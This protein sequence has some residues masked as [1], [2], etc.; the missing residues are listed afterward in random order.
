MNY[1]CMAV[2]HN[3]SMQPFSVSRNEMASGW[4]LNSVYNAFTKVKWLASLMQTK[5]VSTST[6]G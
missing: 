1:L 2:V 5:F 3:I 4:R 6:V